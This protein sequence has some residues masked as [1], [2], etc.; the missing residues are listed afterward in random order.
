MSTIATPTASDRS[1]RGLRETSQSAGSNSRLNARLPRP[2]H[3]R[4]TPRPRPAVC[5]SATINRGNFAAS[6]ARANSWARSCVEPSV[7][8]CSTRRRTG[9]AASR[10]RSNSSAAIRSMLVGNALEPILTNT[11]SNIVAAML[12]DD[13]Q[14]NHSRRAS[15]RA[16][17]SAIRGRSSAAVGSLPLTIRD[18]P[19]IESRLKNSAPARNP[20]SRTRLRA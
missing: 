1:G 2:V 5:S 13:A 4:F 15:G 9:L 10:S 14:A 11:L 18:G 19:D 3:Q 7:A 16:G 12:A 20:F 8:W 6:P 17:T